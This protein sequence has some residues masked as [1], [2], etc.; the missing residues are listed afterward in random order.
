MTGFSTQTAQMSQAAS[1]VDDVNARITS[2]LSSLFA[3]VESVQSHWQGQASTQFQ[4]LMT[5]W[6]DDTKKLNVALRGISEELAASGKS[7]SAQ[8]EA[9][10]Q[11]VRTAGSGLN[12]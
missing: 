1:Q 11:A 6:N 10:E 7:Y 8:D 3:E 12:M 5:R 9:N 4:S 2:L